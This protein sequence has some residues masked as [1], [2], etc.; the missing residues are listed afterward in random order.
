MDVPVKIGVGVLVL[1]SA[2]MILFFDDRFF[3]LWRMSQ[4]SPKIYSLKEI[5]D[6]VWRS[7]LSNPL[8]RRSMFNPSLLY[9]ASRDRW[10]VLARYTRGRRL[11]QCLIQ[12][13]LDDDDVKLRN[14]TYRASMIL[15][16]FNGDFE[17]LS[18]EPVY[19]NKFGGSRNPL[20]W[21]GEDPR[22]YLDAGGKKIVQATIHGRNGEIRLG[23]GELV[24]IDGKLIWNVTTV[25]QS[26]RPEKNW[27]STPLSRD[28]SRVF[29]TDVSP[30]WR[31]CT[32][33]Q[34]GVPTTVF[35][36][37]SPSVLRRLRCTSPCRRFSAHTMLTCLHS[38]HPY[39]TYFLEFDSNRLLP[40]RMSP[41][42]DFSPDKSYIEFASGLE[43][44]GNNVY[45]GVGLNDAQF[46]IYRLSRTD[47]AGFMNISF[48]YDG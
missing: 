10:L 18:E 4:R 13:L 48:S 9:E 14:E 8:R 34:T 23:H 32:L 43:I 40:I 6:V 42:L 38:A 47:V 21:Q 45:I 41:P 46:E 25:V 15:Y 19:V 16:I 30:R 12:Y 22:L 2:F 5:R 44:V 26:S 1:I 36:M 3:V 29:L 7:P 11:G 20:F 27:S 33:S 35:D 37:N 17:K 39:K 24:R 31:F 28:G